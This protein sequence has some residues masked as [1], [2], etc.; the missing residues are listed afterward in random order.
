[1]NE[2][3][4][5]AYMNLK[6][7]I[8][9]SVNSRAS[10]IHFECFKDEGLIRHRI[11]GVLKP[12]KHLSHDQYSA[13]CNEIKL[14]AEMDSHITNAVQDGRITFDDDPD[15]DLR[16]HLSPSVFGETVVIRILSRAT[17]LLALE[18]QGFSNEQLEQIKRWMTKP[19]GLI[20]VS[21][22]TGSGKT[23]T[24]YSILDKL[25][26]ETI[27]IITIED[28]VEYII[29]GIVQ[30]PINP[31]VGRTF[32]STMRS[33]MR[34]DPDVIMVGEIRDLKT[35]QI[36]IQMALTG[37]LVFSSLHTQTASESIVRIH[38]IG[39]EP[40][41]INNTLIGTIS[42]RLARK[43]C[44]HCKE[45]HIPDDL[46]METLGLSAGNYYRP[47]GCEKCGY[48]G[49]HGRMG[50]F[51]ILEMNQEIKEMLLKECNEE[52]L[53]ELAIKQ[54]MITMRQGG[55][56]KAAQGITSIEEVMRVAGAS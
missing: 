30:I 5:K 34:Q 16:V 2:N 10:D 47:K 43:L 18:K 55:L 53:R 11:D 3:N 48:S 25:N 38:D 42:Q 24:L 44:E 13:I 4:Q 41:L 26:K 22:P 29:Q 6:E 33:V 51:E 49:Y 27:K 40:F 9:T 45:E 32:P 46:Q 36:I 21:G 28:P 14:M 17:P 31:K 20:L 19:Y 39:V 7:I 56:E 15:K 37:H 23:T 12:I 1:M 54:G 35:L 52:E 50:I 8:T